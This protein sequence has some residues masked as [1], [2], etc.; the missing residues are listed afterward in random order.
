MIIVYIRWTNIPE[1]K[2]LLKRFRIHK[3]LL[4]IHRQYGIQVISKFHIVPTLL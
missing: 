2:Q 4:Y 1:I 3:I